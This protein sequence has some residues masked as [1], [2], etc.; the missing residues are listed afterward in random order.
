MTLTL[1]A[2]QIMR[3]LS[4]NHATK[5]YKVPCTTLRSRHLGI[6]SRYNTKPNSRKLTDLKE[7]VI[8]RYILNLDS[9]SFPLRIRY[10]EDIA[11]RI[12]LERGV[13]CVGKNWTSNFV[14]RQLELSTRFNRRI[15]YQ[16]VLSKDLDMYNAWF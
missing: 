2:L 5:I 11:N 16:R 8:V 9:R 14:Q 15:D 1:N 13:G 3:K 7:I 6:P 12:L 10:V 4:L